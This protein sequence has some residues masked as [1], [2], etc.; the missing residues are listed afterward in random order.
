VCDRTDKVEYPSAMV[1]DNAVTLHLFSAPDCKTFHR[2]P[3]G[4]HFHVGHHRAAAGD[5]CK[6]AHQF[7]PPVYPRPR[8]R[9]RGPKR[10]R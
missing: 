2:Y 6:A 5:A 3:C 8:P 9:R 10:P 7:K 1:A 4:D